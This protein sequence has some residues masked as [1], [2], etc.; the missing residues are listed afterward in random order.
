LK[1]L[2]II[3][4]AL[5]VGLHAAAT[6]LTGTVVKVYDGDTLTLRT[7]DGK[8]HSIRFEHIDAPEV[9]PK[10]NYG[11]TSR[12][13]LRALVLNKSVS[14]KVSGQDRYKRN[15]GVVYLGQTNIN[16]EMVAKGHAWHYKAYSKDPQYAV[17]ETQAKQAKIGLWAQANPVP[18]WSFRQQQQQQQGVTQQQQGA[19]Q[20]QQGVTQQQQGATQQQQGVTP[21]FNPTTN[22]GTSY[23]SPQS[24]LKNFLRPAGKEPTA[25]YSISK[26]GFIFE[27]DAGFAR[28]IQL[29]KNQQ[30]N[31]TSAPTQTVATKQVRVTGASRPK[32]SVVSQ[33][34]SMTARRSQKNS[35]SGRAKRQR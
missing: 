24:Y 29:R 31:L 28:R 35:N 13:A 27:G 19:T 14:V 6:T 32:P 15:L 3:L 8:E 33:R 30:L 18:P 22:N 26:Q 1:Y 34:F 7:V 20:Q 25:Q 17:A 21:P 12:D 16:L 11:T 10:Q 2:L 23:F 9:N 4:F 5:Q